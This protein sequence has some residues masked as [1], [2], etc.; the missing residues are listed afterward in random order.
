MK[1]IKLCNSNFT[2]FLICTMLA[3]LTK[4]ATNIKQKTILLKFRGMVYLAINMRHQK[5]QCHTINMLH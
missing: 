1:S 3:T 4:N 2:S 5:L